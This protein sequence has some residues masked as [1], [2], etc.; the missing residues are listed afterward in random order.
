MIRLIVEKFRLLQ[1][2]GSLH[3][4]LKL[5][6]KDI[7]QML[8]IILLIEAEINVDSVSHYN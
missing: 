8:S 4:P 5:Q 3:D 6:K 1:N 7:L 2:K